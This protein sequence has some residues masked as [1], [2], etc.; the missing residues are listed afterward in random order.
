MTPD[1][2]PDQSSIETISKKEKNPILNGSK[3]PIYLNTQ[4]L[5]SLKNDIDSGA[6]KRERIES[7]SGNLNNPLLGIVTE[8]KEQSQP[9]LLPG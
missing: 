6:K 1:R 8:L 7:I 4:D 9:M 2:T 5:Q 3:T